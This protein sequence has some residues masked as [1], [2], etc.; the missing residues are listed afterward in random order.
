MMAIRPS[1]GITPS[2]GI[3]LAGKK[4]GYQ[5]FLERM[6]RDGVCAITG[7]QEGASLRILI[8]SVDLTFLVTGILVILILVTPIIWHLLMRPKWLSR[9][10]LRLGR[11]QINTLQKC[12]GGLYGEGVS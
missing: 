9:T 1:E 6:A 3:L 7:N 4:F 8:N 2:Y 12:F 10:P 5:S 11:R